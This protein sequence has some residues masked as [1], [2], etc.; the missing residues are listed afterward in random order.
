MTWSP[1]L[2]ANNRPHND[3]QQQH[4]GRGHDLVQHSLY[5]RPQRALGTVHAVDARFG[6]EQG[7]VDVVDGDVTGWQLHVDTAQNADLLY[8]Q[9]E[10][11]QA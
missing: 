4:Q 2:L 7:V 3:R 8:K 10:H 1:Y 5:A 9:Q 11:L 6:R